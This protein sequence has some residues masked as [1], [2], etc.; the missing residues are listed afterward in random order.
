M[1]VLPA[2]VDLTCVAQVRGDLLAA[3]SGDVS[4]LIADMTGTAFCDS[5]GV[6]ALVEASR[7]AADRGIQ[8]RLVV[9]SAAVRKV[10]TLMGITELVPVYREL[11]AAMSDAPEPQRPD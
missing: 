6:R 8:L 4:V 2:E 3:L 5:A 10:F 1:L 7:A 9:P 11:A